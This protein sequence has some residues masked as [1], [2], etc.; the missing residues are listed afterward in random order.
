MASFLKF[1]EEVENTFPSEYLINVHDFILTEFECLK[2]C[3]QN[4]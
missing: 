3:F 2:G 1:P 4:Y